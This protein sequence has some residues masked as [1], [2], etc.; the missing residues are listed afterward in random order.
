MQ[1]DLRDSGSIPGSGR[2]PWRRARQPTPAFLPAESQ[3]QRSLA[4]GSPRGHK[5][6]DLKQ[7]KRLSIY[8]Q[9][10]RYKNISFYCSLLCFE[11]NALKKKKQVEG[12]GQTCVDQVSGTIFPTAFAHFLSWYH[13]LVILAICQSFSLLSFQ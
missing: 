4:G 5:E 8:A 3:G 10:H 9:R 7:L 1:A 11:Y 12:L 13:I 2:F 6:S